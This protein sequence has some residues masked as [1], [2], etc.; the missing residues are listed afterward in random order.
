[1][2]P[3][4]SFFFDKRYRYPV[5]QLKTLN[6]YL[7]QQ[8]LL[9]LVKSKT[10]PFQSKR[11]VFKYKARIYLFGISYCTHNTI[12]IVIIVDT[13]LPQREQNLFIVSMDKSKQDHLLE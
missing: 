7:N 9:K 3:K 8:P 5:L 11:I 6:F 2:Y 1:M 13:I 12:K 4:T 10:A